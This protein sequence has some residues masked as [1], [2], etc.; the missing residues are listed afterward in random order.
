M[1][2]RMVYRLIMQVHALIV[3]LGGAWSVT[4][5]DFDLVAKL[6]RDAEAAENSRREAAERL[7]IYERDFRYRVEKDFTVMPR[8]INARRSIQLSWSRKTPP[9]YLVGDDGFW[10]YVQTRDEM[11][12]QD[13]VTLPAADDDRDYNF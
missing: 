1:I 7:A 8:I 2:I 4:F 3:A 5:Y 10:R 9:T 6:R 13:A 12:A 11:N